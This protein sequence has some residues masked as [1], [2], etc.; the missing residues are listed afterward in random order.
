MGEEPA[1]GT[2]VMKRALV[3]VE[4]F[5]EERLVKDVLQEHFW[6]MDLHLAPAIL[7]TKRV[8]D[9][10]NFKGGVSNFKKF[11]NDVRRLLYGAGDALVTT[12]LDYDGLPTDFPGMKTRPAAG[13]IARVSHVERS[14]AAHF[15]DPNYFYP[16]SHFTSSRLRCFLLLKNYPGP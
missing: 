6:A 7:V 5:T 1:R 14:I 8:K 15:G 11:E 3:L 9:G 16:I 2:A 10:P 13:P 12:F 4:G